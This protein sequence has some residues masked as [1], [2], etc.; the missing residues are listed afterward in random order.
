MA[1]L[2]DGSFLEERCKRQISAEWNKKAAPSSWADAYEQFLT[3]IENCPTVDAVP[4]VR[5]LECVMW[6]KYENTAG[7]GY[8]HN[9]RF[10]FRYG[11]AGG[12]NELAF[13]PITE[14]EFSCSY[15]KRK[16][17]DE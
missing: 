13:K 17:G 1:R 11:G 5:C 9:K 2:I 4:V 12:S 15:G 14:P 8:C 10:M 6:E 16:G 3:D 7:C